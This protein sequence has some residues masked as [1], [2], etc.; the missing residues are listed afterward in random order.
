MPTFPAVSDA[1]LEAWLRID[2]GQDSATIAMLVG[3]ATEYVEGVTGLVLGLA[4]YRI[5]FDEIDCAYRLP[6]EPI[7]SITS[8]EYL[9]AEGELQPIEDWVTA[10]GYLHFPSIPLGA[11]LVTVEAGYHTP[12]TIPISLCHAIALLVSEGYNSREALSENTIK[13]VDR[14]CQRYKRF[15]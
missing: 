3:S 10:R 13:A 7:Q 11:P 1:D 4:A 2:T 15:W 6:I 14:L 5:E 8:V 12:E 9:D